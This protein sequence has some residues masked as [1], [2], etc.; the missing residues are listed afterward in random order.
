MTLQ[1]KPKKER[2]GGGGLTRF[3]WIINFLKANLRIGKE[4]FERCWPW[5]LSYLFD[6]R[7]T[8]TIQWHTNCDAGADHKIVVYLSLLNPSQVQ[9][10]ASELYM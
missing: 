7:K 5:H 8:T 2:V 1:E 6:S 10:G 4:K 9:R 3:V